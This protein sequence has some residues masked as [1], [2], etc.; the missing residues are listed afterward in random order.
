MSHFHLPNPQLLGGLSHLCSH[1]N[2]HTCSC[3]KSSKLVMGVRLLK[4]WKLCQHYLMLPESQILKMLKKESNYQDISTRLF[5]NKQ[6]QFLNMTNLRRTQRI[7]LCPV[8]CH[9]ILA[10][11]EK[12]LL[13]AATTHNKREVVTFDSRCFFCFSHSTTRKH[14][15]S[16]WFLGYELVLHKDSETDSVT[17][18]GCQMPFAL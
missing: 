14:W 18:S 15:R 7:P 3:G 5:N 13:F 2:S 8:V 17:G 1:D 12:Q 6:G 16:S 9:S 4:G 10:L 11:M